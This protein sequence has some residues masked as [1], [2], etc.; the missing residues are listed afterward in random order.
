MM[1]SAITL[2]GNIHGHLV[3][4]LSPQVTQT[5]HDIAEEDTRRRQRA[6]PLAQNY[7]QHDSDTAT[8]TQK[9]P[10]SPPT[11]A[12]EADQGATGSSAP[13]TRS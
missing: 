4:E 10:P 5:P 8:T 7:L 1:S 2:M 13:N 12:T 11:E 6:K 9:P 3:I